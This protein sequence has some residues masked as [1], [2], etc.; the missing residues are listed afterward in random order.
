MEGS[1]HEQIWPKWDPKALIKDEIEVVVQVNGKLRGRLT[2]SA[3]A[4]REEMEKIALGHEK[5]KEFIAGKNIVRVIAV[6]KKLVNI[7]VR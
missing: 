7:V 5:I 2:I 1:V 4:T 6:P 3:E